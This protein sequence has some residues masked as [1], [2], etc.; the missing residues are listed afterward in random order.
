MTK[1]KYFNATLAAE[2]AASGVA[3]VAPTAV[4]AS[5]KDLKKTDYFYYDIINLQQRGIIQG[6]VLSDRM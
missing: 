4:E 3:V 5:F 6:M 1:K 2:L